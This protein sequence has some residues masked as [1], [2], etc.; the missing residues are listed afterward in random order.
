MPDKIALVAGGGLL[1]ELVAR[2]KKDSVFVAALRDH[3]EKS[4]PLSYDHE[5]FSLGSVG[6]LMS[7]C[8]RRGITTLVFAGHVRRPPLWRL[9]LGHGLDRDGLALLWSLFFKRHGDDALL[10]RIARFF[11]THGFH[12]IGADD[13]V[14]RVTVHKGVLTRATPERSHEHD[15]RY[16][17]NAL[18][19]HAV[20]DK[21]QAAIV[22]NGV[23]LGLEGA[24]GTDVLIKQHGKDGA[25]LIKIKK[26]QQDRRLDLPTIGPDTVTNCARM[27][28]SGIAVQA[29]DTIFLQP[30]KCINLA[31]AA[32]IFIYGFSV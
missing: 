16:A 13:I 21:G 14:P 2:E 7:A 27:G 17:L 32:G 20:A 18:L 25:I 4:W 28:F 15:I 6:S 1:P 8:R 24:G 5:W 9:L 12:V 31:D 22:K 23:V 29:D 10:R 26:P 3:A 19:P 30:E 11:S